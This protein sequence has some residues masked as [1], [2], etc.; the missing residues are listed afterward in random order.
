[1][2]Q[3]VDRRGSDFG[4]GSAVDL[5]VGRLPLGIANRAQGNL[6][7]RAPRERN[8]TKKP[9]MNLL[10]PF[11]ME[12]S[13]AR[14]EAPIATLRAHDNIAFALIAARDAHSELSTLDPINPRT[15]H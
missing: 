7:S 1:M 6:R 9:E 8:I 15:L 10:L 14:G 4:H 13:G 12:G 2:L 5:I 3:G 11:L